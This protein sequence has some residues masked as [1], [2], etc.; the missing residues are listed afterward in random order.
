ME[1]L[2]DLWESIT[3]ILIKPGTASL[4]IGISKRF[5]LFQ[6]MQK[7]VKF[8]EEDPYLNFITVLKSYKIL[9]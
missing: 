6:A 2:K 1:K 4:T 9:G 7:L 5:F 3:P 8:M